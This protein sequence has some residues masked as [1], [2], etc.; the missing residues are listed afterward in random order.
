M[1]DRTLHLPVAAQDSVE[2][3]VELAQLGE[4]CGYRRAWVPET[5]GRDAVTIMTR[6]AT[7]TEEIGIGPSILNTYSRSPGVLAQTAAS[8]QEVSNGRLRLGV[9][10]SGPAVIEGWH[11]ESFDQPLRR[12]RETIEI[13]QQALSGEPVEYDGHVFSLSGF[14]LRCEP[15]AEP[16]PVDAAAMGPTAVEMAGRFADGWHAT[17]FT[18]DGMRERLGDLERGADLGDRDPEDIRVTLAVTACALPDGERARELV[19]RHAAF[20]IGG[21]G[22]FYRDSLAAQGHESLAHEVAS[23]WANGDREHAAAMVR[24]E[25]L[26]ELGA[27][28]TPAETRE[29]L[30]S[31]EAIDGLDAVAVS[32]P[33]EA[34]R[35]TVRETIEVLGPEA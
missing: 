20:Y 25:V 2:S 7:D 16:V 27:A 22:T 34:S 10:P 17:M 9:G 8:L 21:M 14:R 15:P 28:G 1:T 24:D 30:E 11:G 13:I 6:M 29:A 35:S 23:A 26:D 19:A 3:F 5:W 31:F 12:S 18:R 33:R 32:F 4:Q